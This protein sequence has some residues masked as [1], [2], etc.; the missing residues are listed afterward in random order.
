MTGADGESGVLQ[1]SGGDVAPLLSLTLTDGVMECV[2]L[3]GLSAYFVCLVCS[4]LGGGVLAGGSG[5]CCSPSFLLFTALWTKMVFLPSVISNV[6]DVPPTLV[7]T[8][9]SEEKEKRA[10][11]HTRKRP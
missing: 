7:L 11:R 2:F 1:R 8:M 10:Q 4:F 6:S 5:R 9:E 3:S